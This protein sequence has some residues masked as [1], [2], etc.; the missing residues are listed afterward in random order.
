M[1]SNANE[2]YLDTLRLIDNY[3]GE[4]RLPSNRNSGLPFEGVFGDT[5]ELRVLEHL[6]DNFD[7][8]FNITEISQGCTLSRPTVHKVVKKLVKAGA[9]DALPRRGNMVFYKI[10]GESHI[11]KGLG[12]IRASKYLEQ[13]P[14]DAEQVLQE[15]LEQPNRITRLR[16]LKT[17]VVHDPEHSK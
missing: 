5:C 17:Q 9:V 6:M 16:R 15:T 1:V 11:V 14:K 3:A 4:S 10:N 12:N 2:R 7:I 8:D 13:M